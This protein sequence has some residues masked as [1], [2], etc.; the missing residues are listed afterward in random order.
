MGRKMAD[1]RVP[2]TEMELQKAHHLVLAMVQHL[3]FV[4]G[5]LMVPLWVHEKAHWKVNH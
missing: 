3:G 1:W 4:K 5:P 2:K